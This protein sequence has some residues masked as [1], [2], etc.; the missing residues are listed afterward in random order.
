LIQ[1][2]DSYSPSQIFGN[3]FDFAL[4][5]F[6][7]KSKQKSKI[8]GKQILLEEFEKGLRRFVLSPK[9]EEKFRARGE[10]ALSD[11]YDEY[12]SSWTP[13]VEVQFHVERNFELDSKDILKIS[14][15]LDKIEYLDDL[16]SAKIN[17]I[18]HKTGKSFSEKTK[19][20]RADYERQLVFYKLLL[21]GYE[22]KD[23]KI[24]RSILDFVEKNKKG[25]FEQ[26]SLDINEE[27]LEKLR[28]EINTCAQEVLSMEFFK[29]GC[30]K[31]DCQWCRI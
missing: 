30:R 9:D 6:F 7:K 17:I 2:P 27:A 16:F 12:S 5:N 11:Y 25:K 22:K 26:Y 23:F 21:L 15:I 18:D 19:E 28:Q 10:K 13:K 8:L 31:K 14:G 24:N 29:K 3:I 1:I 4:N 20:Q